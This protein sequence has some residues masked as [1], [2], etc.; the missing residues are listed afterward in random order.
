MTASRKR[1]NFMEKLKL[2]IFDAIQ[3]KNENEIGKCDICKVKT[4]I[5]KV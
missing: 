3:S 2:K 1:N 4:A 5:P